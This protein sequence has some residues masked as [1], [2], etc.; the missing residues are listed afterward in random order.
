M[1]ELTTLSPLHLLQGG[2]CRGEVFFLQLHGMFVLFAAFESLV[3]TS[4]VGISSSLFTRLG[5][6]IYIVFNQMQFL[7]V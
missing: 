5:S 7:L 2:S 4:Q 6:P 1:V 3:N